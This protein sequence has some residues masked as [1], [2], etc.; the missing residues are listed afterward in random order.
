MAF[1][2]NTILTKY[3]LDKLDNYLYNYTPVYNEAGERID[4]PIDL[5][6]FHFTKIVISN[7]FSKLDILTEKLANE[8]YR[9]PIDKI[10]QNGSILTIHS[11]ISED[12]AGLKIQQVGL[13]ETVDGVD[14]LFAYG[15]I[16]SYK[17]ATD[18]NLIINLEFNIENVQMYRDKLN[19]KVI[20]P[21]VIPVKDGEKVLYTFADVTDILQHTIK[22]NHDEFGSQPIQVGFDKERERR[23]VEKDVIDM[24]LYTNSLS[25]STP[26]D[27][28]HL[29]ET[30]LLTY[31]IR[32]LAR[33]DSYLTFDNGKFISTGDTCNF[34]SK[35]SLMLQGSFVSEPSIIINKILPDGTAFNFKL[36]TENNSLVLTLGGETGTLTYTVPLTQWGHIS[37]NDYV[38][39]FTFDGVEVHY[40]LNRDEVIGTLINNGY[41]VAKNA[42]NMVLSN[43]VS[44]TSIYNN[45]QQVDSIWFYADCLDKERVQELVKVHNYLF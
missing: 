8:I 28:F 44:E 7:D 25:I 12:I 4:T 19:I 11:N 34:L 2:Q 1:V 36:E 35:G 21:E 16:D 9:L 17:P 38:H 42:D 23:K 41:S 30:D 33:D 26:S 5:A 6:E 22:R 13:Y 24:L 31:Q 15:N 40:Y 32:N 45:R 14:Y 18:Y 39:T 10:E 3:A 20:Q 29:D 37:S 27:A 43:A